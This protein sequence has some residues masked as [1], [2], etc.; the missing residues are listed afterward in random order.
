MMLKDLK[1]KLELEKIQRRICVWWT[2]AKLS[3]GQAAKLL[4]M[5]RVEA[6]K[7]R[8]KFGIEEA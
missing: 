6:R 3:E 8:E 1:D 2:K 5:D 4:G 7:L